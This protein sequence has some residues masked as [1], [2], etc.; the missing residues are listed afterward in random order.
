MFA[1]L[2]PSVAEKKK[3]HGQVIVLLM[4]VVELPASFSFRCGNRGSSLQHQGYTDGLVCEG[5][6]KE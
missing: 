4:A 5:K 1:C 2:N 6:T 3:N